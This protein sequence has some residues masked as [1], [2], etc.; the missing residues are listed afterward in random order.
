MNVVETIVV[1]AVVIYLQGFWT[2]IPA[3]SIR[4][5]G[6]RGCLLVKLFYTS[7]MPIMLQSALSSNVFLISQMLYSRFSD[8]LLVRLIGV[9]EP[10]EG[11]AQLFATSGVSYYMY[12]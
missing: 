1:F 11:S 7:N 12:V 10:K 6:Q 8:N 2:R 4:R 5:R 3:E 9:W